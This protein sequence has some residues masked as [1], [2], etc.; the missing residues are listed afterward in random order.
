MPTSSQ[1]IMILNGGALVI[2]FVTF[3]W[4]ARHYIT[5]IAPSLD[6][7]QLTVQTN[8]GVTEKLLES[9]A[10][11]FRELSVSNHNVA[12]ALDLLTRT[13]EQSENAIARHEQVS[14]TQYG[15]AIGK[16]EENTKLLEAVRMDLMRHATNCEARCIERRRIDL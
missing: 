12:T 5:R 2:V 4:A 6:A 7:L 1:A 13:M 8:Q 14:G 9:T 3:I 10:S 11:A 16:V 15:T